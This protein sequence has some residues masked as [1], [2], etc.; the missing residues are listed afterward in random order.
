M[1][2]SELDLS[3]TVMYEILYD[4]SKPKYDK[5]TKLCYMDTGI[6]HV[7]TEDIYKYISEYDE[8]R[9]DTSSFKIGRLFCLKKKQKSIWI[10]EG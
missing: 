4:Y 7:K 8:I 1:T 9:F 10:N 5:N 2:L 6:V 3:R